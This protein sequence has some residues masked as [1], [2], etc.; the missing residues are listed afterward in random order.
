MTDEYNL[1][2]KVMEIVKIVTEEWTKRI[3]GQNQRISSV[4]VARIVEA[5]ISS[6][7][8]QMLDGL[9]KTAASPDESKVIAIRVDW[10]QEM[11]WGLEILRGNEGEKLH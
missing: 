8:Y 1:D 3:A 11:S 4:D 10:Q 5:V 6:K 7:M 2:A 9:E